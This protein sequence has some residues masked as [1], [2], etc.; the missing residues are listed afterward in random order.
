MTELCFN[1]EDDQRLKQ[2]EKERQFHLNQLKGL[3]SQVSQ[4]QK[5]LNERKETLDQKEKEML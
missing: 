3:F 1:K 4:T 5:A 2:A